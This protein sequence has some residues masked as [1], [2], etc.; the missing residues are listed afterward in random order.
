M[1][2][3]FR[4]LADQGKAVLISSHI[5]DEMDRLADRILFI[6]RGRILASGTLSEIR[7]MLADYP[8]RLRVTVDRARDLAVRLMQLPSVL[9]VDLELSGEKKTADGLRLQ[10]QR[11]Q[12]FFRDFGDIV[13]EEKLDVDRMQ[14]LDGSTE[15]VF[16]YLREQALR[17]HR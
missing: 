1:V 8:M 4:E 17:P 16:D 13:I 11:P 3:L 2:H 5:L 15:A 10:V 6:W 12:E 9:S 14:V 7:E